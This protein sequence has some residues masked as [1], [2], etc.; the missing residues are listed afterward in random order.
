MVAVSSHAS[1]WTHQQPRMTRWYTIWSFT[2][3]HTEHHIQWCPLRLLVFATV[4]GSA[5][6]Q[7]GSSRLPHSLL[8]PKILN[9]F[10]S[11]PS[12]FFIV[13]MGGCNMRHIWHLGHFNLI[14]VECRK[15]QFYTVAEI[16]FLFHCLNSKI[17]L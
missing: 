7:G 6:W 16:T 9:V 13:K 12:F 2:A 14:S 15:C 3:V 17:L 5:L 11:H 4:S 8:G 10:L 1:P